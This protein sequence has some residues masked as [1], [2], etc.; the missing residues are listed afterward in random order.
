[1]YMFL[2]SK[3]EQVQL[4]LGVW[5]KFVQNHLAIISK[6]YYIQ[7]KIFFRATIFLYSPC[8][9]LEDIKDGLS[10]KF[11]RFIIGQNCAM[12]TNEVARA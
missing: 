4:L 6:L 5:F 1:M 3:F 11:R 2:S 12:C 7:R 9:N 8:P 10:Y